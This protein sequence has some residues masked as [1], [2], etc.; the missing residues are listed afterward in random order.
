MADDVAQSMNGKRAG[1]L[2]QLA[3]AMALCPL[4]LTLMY[5][6]ASIATGTRSISGTSEAQIYQYEWQARLFT[7]ATQLES[8]IRGKPIETAWLVAPE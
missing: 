6:G 4:A 5:F 7:P 8:V 3:V 2:L 1:R